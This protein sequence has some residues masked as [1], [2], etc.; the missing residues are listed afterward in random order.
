[1]LTDCHLTSR[2]LFTA[3]S[4]TATT[5]SSLGRS[6]GSRAINAKPWQII[7]DPAR[8]NLVGKPHMKSS[9]SQKLSLRKTGQHIKMSISADKTPQRPFPDNNDQKQTNIPAE[10]IKV[11]SFVPKTPYDQV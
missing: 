7:Y 2:T 11:P 4:L 9:A 6:F 5:G 10:R 8:K 1:M 3:S